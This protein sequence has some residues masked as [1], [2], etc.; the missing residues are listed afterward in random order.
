MIRFLITGHVDHGKSTLGGQL[1]YQCGKLE[2]RE[3]QKVFDEAEK[4]KMSSFKWARLLDTNSDEK[5]RGVT[6]E[7]NEIEFKYEG[8]NFKLIDTPGHKMC[9]RHLIDGIYRNLNEG[10][11]IGVLV[12]S[13]LTGELQSSLDQIK[14][15][16]L[17]M[18]AIGINSVIIAINKLDKVNWDRSYFETAKKSILP[19]LKS[20]RFKQLSFSACSGI[21][22][23]GITENS[24]KEF[25]D[26]PSLIDSII[27]SYCSA[28]ITDKSPQQCKVNSIYETNTIIANIFILDCNIFSPGYETMIHLTSGEFLFVVDKMIK[29]PEDKKK[30]YFLKTGDFCKVTLNLKDQKE[31]AMIGINKRIILRTSDKTIGYGVIVEK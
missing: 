4:D 26:I 10:P 16:I 13:C 5:E 12:L 1:L 14:E 18:K 15:N 17:L 7:C 23:I 24:H 6:V 31:K 3:V 25:E 27:D 20:A 29:I 19:L 22:G 30:Y 11:V 8:N 2:K 21:D 28:L 9:I